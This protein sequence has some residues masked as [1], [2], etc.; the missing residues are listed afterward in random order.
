MSSKVVIWHTFSGNSIFRVVLKYRLGRFY[1]YK[2]YYI[3]YYSSIFH[4]AN[5]IKQCDITRSTLYI[6]IKC[7]YLPMLFSDMISMYKIYG[8]TS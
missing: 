2:F 6:P 3:Y 8:K 5:K 1:V 7:D 4:V